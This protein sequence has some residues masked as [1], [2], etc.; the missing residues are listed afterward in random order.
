MATDNSS[1]DK[2]LL[3]RQWNN[4]LLANNAWWPRLSHTSRVYTHEG[5]DFVL[6]E[7]D[8]GQPRVISLLTVTGYGLHADRGP[9]IAIQQ[10][11]LSV[12]H[13]VGVLPGMISPGI[14]AWVPAF[15]TIRYT[16]QD[17]NDPRSARRLTVPMCIRTLHRPGLLVDGAR[18]L[19]P[20][21]EFRKSWPD[22]S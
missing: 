20:L 6:W 12:R 2:V 7:A 10:T 21:S 19:T 18:Y 5:M 15:A 13:H 16:P 22:V 17:Y 8:D 9:T 14:F 4:E 3:E 11:E 1:Q